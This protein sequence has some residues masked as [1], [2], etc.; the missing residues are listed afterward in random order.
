MI[1]LPNMGQ[2]LF[3]NWELNPYKATRQSEYEKDRKKATK[4]FSSN[5][6]NSPNPI[7]TGCT[8]RGMRCRGLYKKSET[9]LCINFQNNICREQEMT[10]YTK[11]IA[12][13]VFTKN[14]R[15]RERQ[16]DICV[17]GRGIEM[18]GITKPKGLFIYRDICKKNIS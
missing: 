14:C 7:R 8:I 17:V 18:D 2:F 16:Q 9:N 3:S 6:L 5:N 15:F 12:L 10:L 11:L 13:S 4:Y 1:N